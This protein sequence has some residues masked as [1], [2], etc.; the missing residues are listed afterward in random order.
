MDKLPSSGS[1]D[2]GQLEVI[3]DAA[4][5]VE[6]GV[7]TSIDSLKKIQEKLSMQK[8]K[9]VFNE[10][11]FDCVCLP[12]FID[13]HTHMCYAGDRSY[14]F[15]NRLKGKSYLEIAEGGGGISTTVKSTRKASIKQLERDLTE[16]C[17]KKLSQ[18]VTTCEVKSG[19]GLTIK[20]EIKILKAIKS[21]NES[22]TLKLIPTCL[23][24][25]IVPSEY[26]NESLYLKDI[27][28]NL[29]PFLQE[30]NLS[31][32]ID[33]FIDKGAFTVEG[34]RSYLKAAKKCGFDIIIH[35]DQFSLGGARLGAELKALSVDHLEVSDNQVFTALKKAGVIPIVLPGASLGL[36]I[37]FAPARKI[38]DAGLPLVLASDWN[39]GSAPMGNLLTQAS[40]IAMVEK[41]TNAEVF[42]SITERAARA[43]KLN[44]VGV[45]KK[46]MK[47]NFVIFPCQHYE[48]ILYNQ[49][50][51]L[52]SQVY[53][54]GKEI[55][56]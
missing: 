46:G 53:V 55:N 50:N 48:E 49:G 10:I 27:K 15:S 40:I 3:L 2:D 19:Y 8:Q 34:A 30:N 24:A 47:A 22:Q 7:I 1:I 43:L 52:P 26:S 54:E 28:N 23:A 38:L 4:I 51:L 36:G 14:D 56:F 31:N 35:A 11:D 45:L 13:A 12:G 44:N 32:R 39:P 29:F 17:Y 16:R 42:A 20:D 33:I 41:L 5:L 6:N 9:Y 37:P 21:V 18:G 25:H